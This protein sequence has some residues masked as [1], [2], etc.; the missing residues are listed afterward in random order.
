MS[1]II[2]N[3]AISRDA[4]VST[5]GKA[6]QGGADPGQ[7]VRPAGPV[8]PDQAQQA[9]GEHG[10]DG[11]GEEH[12]AER[13]ASGGT[14]VSSSEQVHGIPFRSSRPCNTRERDIAN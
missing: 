3:R 1:H 14:R 12:L 2:P 10:A 8:E 5:V 11:G 7:D 6:T 13:G 4:V 9:G